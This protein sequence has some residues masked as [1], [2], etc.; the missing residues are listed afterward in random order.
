MAL[1]G[2]ALVCFV[3]KRLRFGSAASLR[4]VLA[5]GLALL[6]VVVPTPGRAEAP[7]AGVV[8]ARDAGRFGRL[9]FRFAEPVT[10]NVRVSGGVLV[11][12]FDRPVAIAEAK[13]AAAL[14][15]YL[16]AVRIDPDQKSM[17]FALV[18]PV[19]ADLKDAAEQ[20][21]LD[22]LP[23]AWRGPPPPLPPDVVADL[24]R[25]ARVARDAARQAAEKAAAMPWPLRVQVS[26]TEQ[27]LRLAFLLPPGAAAQLIQQ[28]RRAEVTI[29]GPVAVAPEVVRAALAGHVRDVA[30][31]AG[32]SGGV[33]RFAVPDGVA[34][35]GISDGDVFFVDLIRPRVSRD[36][37]EAPPPAIAMAPGAA[38]PVIDAPVR[39]TDAAP[40]MRAPSAAP[41]MGPEGGVSAHAARATIAAHGEGLRINLTPRLPLA[42]FER[43]GAV[44]MA[45]RGTRSFQPPRSDAVTD[46][47]VRDVD[48]AQHDGW[49]LF[50]VT[51]L[52]PGLVSVQASADGWRVD[53]GPSIDSV[54]EPVRIT[55]GSD[56]GGHRT[57][58]AR[59]AASAEP[60]Q[61]DDPDTGEPIVLVP[62]SGPVQAVVKPQTFV[63]FML[64]RTALGLVVVP[65]VDDLKVASALD[66]VSITRDAG[67][68]LSGEG[69]TVVQAEA[70]VEMVVSADQWNQ[71]RRGAI[72]DGERALLSAAA[73]TRKT[74]RSPARQRLAEFYLSNGLS[75]EA[76]GVLQVIA[77]DDPGYAR[78][79]GFALLKVIAD[80]QQGN[81]ADAAKALA[82]RALENDP[83]GQ[84]WRAYLDVR[85]RRFGPA[86]AGFRRSLGLI[87]QIPDSLQALVRPAVIE[88][89]LEGGDTY[90]ANQQLGEFER[91]DSTLRDG[92]QV[93]LLLG[94][95]A[96]A[97]GRP[98]EAVAAYQAARQGASRPVEAEARLRATLLRGTHQAIADDQAKAE[99][100]TVAM[101][102]RRGEV[103]LLARARLADLHA[104]AGEWRDVFLQSRRGLEILPDHAVT[105]A[106]QEEASRRFAALFLEGKADRLGKVQALAIFN[107]FRWLIPTGGEGDQIVARLTERL[108]D[109][110]LIDQAA[111]LLD[112]QVRHRL[113]GLPRAQTATRLALLQLVNGKPK[114]ALQALRMSRMAQLPADLTRARTILEAR[115]LA[116]QSRGELALDV[117]AAETGSD[118][119]RLRG[120]IHWSGK[121]WRAAAEAYER[122][123][124]DRWQGTSPLTAGERADLIRAGVAFVLAGEALGLDRLRSKFLPKMANSEDAATFKLITLDN[125]AR[126]DAF[127][128]LARA[129][130]SAETL[131]AFLDA[132]R[133]RYPGAAGADAPKAGESGG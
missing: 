58:T 13:I 53:V 119:E 112:H 44:W 51:P 77:A 56:A 52:K 71:D 23:G 39:A 3:M 99:L 110:D 120:D 21:F 76:S 36:L 85:G 42:V 78:G 75:A 111:E 41:P 29:A 19:R 6:V 12:L 84:M 34:A 32:E 109:L 105:R 83:E 8:E 10:A 133:R 11:V 20:M 123:L 7:V 47:L 43:S 86:L 5:L 4:G 87:D 24:A 35:E 22:L 125:A 122:A 74:A 93:S 68:S 66:T 60:V 128:V 2:L 96:E 18:Q 118:I 16:S 90:L 107:E 114:D 79:R 1:V 72:R 26:E 101:I 40:E 124:A 55:R 91:L 80:I 127:R 69:E 126:P 98:A 54:T 130:A 102:W 104:R 15:A 59:L 95:I 89:A 25:R 17:R 63:E 65:R 33:I 37:P 81:L 70:P 82:H 103:E 57:L 116:D 97:S 88:A 14:P 73:A 132:Y 64:P 67:L 129:T 100:E 106:M 131:S 31:D 92:G 49:S 30:T 46:E 121:R 61:V 27:R 38:D 108:Y 9:V 28:D 117:I 115:A 48:G 50:R 45:M 113:K 62:V 94:R